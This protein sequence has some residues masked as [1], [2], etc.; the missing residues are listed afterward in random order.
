MLGS[1]LRRY[2]RRIL[3]IY[4]L[5]SY[6]A[7]FLPV[8][9]A[10]SVNHTIDD[11]TGDSVTGAL[12]DYEPP[13][14]E[15]NWFQ[16]NLC[17]H[18]NMLPNKVIDV[19]KTFNGTWHDTTY[20]PGTLERSVAASFTGTA[21]YVFFIVPNTVP[22]TTT[23]T[24][25]SFTLDDTSAGQPFIHTPDS[26]SDISYQV[27]VFT[28]TN[29]ANT[30]HT[31]KV[32]TGGPN[33]TLM[34][35]DYMI[36]T[37]EE[38]DPSSATV[39]NT[40]SATF[41]SASSTTSSTGGTTSDSRSPPNSGT[42]GSAS[43]PSFSSSS[44]TISAATSQSTSSH[45][46]SSLAASLSPTSTPPADGP[47]HSIKAP[48]PTAGSTLGGTGR[49]GSSIPIGAIVGGVA[50]A[51]AILI[52]LAGV[53]CY[54]RKR[55]R[56][57]SAVRGASPEIRSAYAPSGTSAT[58]SNTMRDLD[59]G[60]GASGPRDG[61]QKLKDSQL[62]DTPLLKS[63][64]PRTDQQTSATELQSTH[65]TETPSTSSPGSSLPPAP[66]HRPSARRPSRLNLG[67][68]AD[69]DDSTTQYTALSGTSSSGRA[70]SRRT[71]G[72]SS[73]RTRGGSSARTGD[74]TLRAE[75]VALRE[76]LLRL[77]DVE[78]EMH[79]MMMEPPPRYEES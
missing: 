9:L 46:V 47:D 74:S 55:R 67:Y 15:D 42:V 58:P 7:R 18:C 28:A 26:S 11:Q 59:A 72:A 53:I 3:H 65:P 20:H 6:S 77:R 21:V 73:T 33:A 70:L 62:L 49:N 27:P 69:G 5:I 64:V 52:L 60:S 54:L 56:R 41:T 32:S 45:S 2:A 43:S 75:V 1:T 35:F 12:P 8:T 37:A 66:A 13:N 79:A 57:R 23:L 39:V 16:G 76:E 29:L 71:G 51:L 44:L 31:I 63:L 22:F 14:V 34:L 78:Q 38:P 48:Q 30:K 25:L 61:L 10:L 19:S 68:P 50:S 36:Y 24:N 40:S 4:G 17:V